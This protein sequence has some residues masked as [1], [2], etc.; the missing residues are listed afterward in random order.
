MD[1]I[2]MLG[3]VRGLAVDHAESP[4]KPKVQI[5]LTGQAEQLVVHSVSPYQEIVRQGRTYW[6]A[7]AIATPVAA[8]TAIPT[9]AACLSIYNGE[10]DGGRSYV[11]NYVWSFVVAVTAITQ[12]HWGMIGCLGQV[13]EAIPT[14]GAPVIKNAAGTFKNDTLCRP[15]IA[16][17]PA[18]TGLAANWFPIGDTC[19]SSVVTLPG[20]SQWIPI[21][22]RI[23]VPPGRYFAVH[24]LGSLTTFTVIMGIGWTEKQLF[25]G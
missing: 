3:K 1:E 22:G 8:V 20:M 12:F 15:V 9:T 5:A 7:N 13:R 14:A 4:Q 2:V 18:G 11:I 21:D 17:L 24:T 10:A 19:Y 25:L 23:I 6:V 16:A